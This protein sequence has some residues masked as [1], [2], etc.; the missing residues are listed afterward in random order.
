MRNFFRMT[1]SVS[2]RYASA[3]RNAEQGKAI[4]PGRLYDRFQIVNPRIERKIGALPIR[5]TITAFVIA[6]KH[7]VAG[8]LAQ[9]VPPDRALPISLE[10][11]EPVRRLHD[12]RA[13]AYGRVRDPRSVVSRAKVNLL[14]HG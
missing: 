9:H 8:E 2:D 10:V 13:C 3:L 1:N 12:R 6:N 11:A 14:F 7:V 4:E 5:Q